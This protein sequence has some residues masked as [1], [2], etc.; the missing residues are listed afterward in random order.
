MKITYYAMPTLLTAAALLAA[1]NGVAAKKNAEMAKSQIVL[2]NSETGKTDS[3]KS[4]DVISAA[5]AM[6][7]FAAKAG[8]PLTVEVKHREITISSEHKKASASTAPKGQPPLPAPPAESAA[9]QVEDKSKTLQNSAAVLSFFRNVGSLPYKMSYKSLC[10]GQDCK[11]AIE[12]VISF[13]SEAP[14]TEPDPPPDAAPKAA[15]KATP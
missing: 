15:P 1:F 9:E 2:R 14:K 13:G 6:E 7:G 12:T 5:N 10:I 8:L 4:A 11:S 3:A